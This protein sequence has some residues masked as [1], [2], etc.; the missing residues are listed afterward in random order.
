MFTYYRRRPGAHAP[1]PRWSSPLLRRLCAPIINKEFTA[2]AP[3]DEVEAHLQ[4]DKVQEA[5]GSRPGPGF[6]EI[7]GGGGRSPLRSLRSAIPF[8]DKVSVSPFIHSLHAPTML[9]GFSPGFMLLGDGPVAVAVVV[10]WRVCV[11]R[12]GA[13]EAG[14][15]KTR[16]WAEP[17]GILLSFT[18]CGQA[19]I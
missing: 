16:E 3:R 15:E 9:R 19:V 8:T 4:L 10:R 12:Q 18:Q 14:K 6:G 13:M 1:S 7:K 5:P 17:G 2:A 11:G